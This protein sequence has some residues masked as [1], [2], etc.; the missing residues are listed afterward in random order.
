MHAFKTEARINDNHQLE[1]TLPEAFPTGVV[2]V[3]VLSASS[4]PP[5]SSATDIRTFSSWIKAQAPIA[6]SRQD[7]EAQIQQ[8]RS[9][10]GED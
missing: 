7:I 4:N 5:S 8:E 1:I 2:E 9:A 3:I 10:W 6:R